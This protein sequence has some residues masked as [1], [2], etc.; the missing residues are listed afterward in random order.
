MRTAR[1]GS[2]THTNIRIGIDAHFPGISRR[3]TEVAGRRLDRIGICPDRLDTEPCRSIVNTA[4]ECTVDRTERT[5]AVQHD[6][7]RLGDI[8]YDRLSVRG[9]SSRDC[10][11]IARHRRNFQSSDIIE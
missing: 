6:V 10:G 4:F 5:C 7:A 9:D 8:A 2:R 11:V 1:I 3:G